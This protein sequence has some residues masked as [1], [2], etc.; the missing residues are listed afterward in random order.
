MGDSY[1][2]MNEKKCTFWVHFRPSGSLMLRGPYFSW[3]ILKIFDVSFEH[4]KEAQ[5]TPDDGAKMAS[6]RAFRGRLVA[7][8]THPFAHV[9]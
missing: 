9:R 5:K 6:N 8:R 4:L 3:R 7:D 2:F 1:D